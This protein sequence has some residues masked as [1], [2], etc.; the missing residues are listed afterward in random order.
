M[1]TFYVFYNTHEF[2]IRI[3]LNNKHGY[4]TS[5]YNC[6]SSQTLEV[7]SCPLRTF[8]GLLILFL[9]LM[10]IVKTVI[11]KFTRCERNGI[12]KILDPLLDLHNIGKK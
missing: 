6:L 4:D 8:R 11:G 10:F 7:L 5:R 12:D 1:Y 2:I 9:F 3:E